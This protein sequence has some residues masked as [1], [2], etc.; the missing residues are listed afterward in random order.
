M[1]DTPSVISTERVPPSDR[2]SFWQHQVESLLTHLECTSSA[3]DSFFG[4]IKVY[5]STPANLLEID[6]ARHAIARTTPKAAQARDEQVLIC[7]Q[8]AGAAI[9]EQDGRQGVLRPGDMTVL[10]TSKSF[11][12]DFP[13]EMAQLV[14][15]VPRTLFRKRVGALERLTATVV[16]AENPLGKMTCEFVGSLARDFERFGP[17]VA[18][19]LNEQ[20][21]DMVAMAFMSSLDGGQPVKTSVTRSMAAYRGRA[22]IEA[23]LRNAALSPW[24]VAEHLGI[25]KRYLSVIFASEGL[26]VERFIRERRLQ[27]CAQDLADRAL[28]IRPIGDIAFAWGFSSLPHFSLSFKTAFGTTPR[29]YRKQALSGLQAR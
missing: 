16:P 10:D 24:D 1:N 26:S 2:L 15:Q 29:E 14:L 18:Q 12:A 13:C 4:S 21:L 23:N 20:A 22:F 11:L 25:S 9:V 5:A 7:I 27:K 28:A 6:A 3:E 17:T 8:S 19:R